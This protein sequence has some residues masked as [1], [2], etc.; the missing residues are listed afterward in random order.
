MTVGPEVQAGSDGVEIKE[1]PGGL[2][3]V[4][5]FKGLDAIGRMWQE[6]LAWVEKSG[7]EVGD[8]QC[9]EELLSAPG[10][11]MT[12]YVFDLYLPLQA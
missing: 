2:F 9:L 6:L 5:R 11:P 10:L 1:M 12:E 3:A 8:A 4:A 7:H